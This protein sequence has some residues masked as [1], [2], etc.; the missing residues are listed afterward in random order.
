MGALALTPRTQTNHS[1]AKVRSH[2]RPK[3]Q[4]PCQGM[5]GVLGLLSSAP[6]AAQLLMGSGMEGLQYS[7]QPH[8]MS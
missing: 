2:T 1:F 8:V 3:L 5:G 6:D 7:L 4:A